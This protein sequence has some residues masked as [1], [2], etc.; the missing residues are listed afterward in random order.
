MAPP[1]RGP[2]RGRQNQGKQHPAANG[3]GMIMNPAK[4]ILMLYQALHHYTLT[5][6]ALANTSDSSTAMHSKKV[7]QLD[8]YFKTAQAN[9]NPEFVAK[10]KQINQNWRKQHLENHL[11]HF[12]KMKNQN[13]QKIKDLKLPKS[14]LLG[15]LGTAKKWAKDNFKR[16]F[17]EA[18]FSEISKI[19][20]DSAMEQAPTVPNTHR[21]PQN[22][23]AP[24]T[25]PVPV[26]RRSAGPRPKSL[27]PSTAAKTPS[28]NTHRGGDPTPGPSN[29]ESES[30]A[31]PPNFAP[32]IDP[33]IAK[34]TPNTRRSKRTEMSPDLSPAEGQAE[35]QKPKSK[36][37][38]ETTH[39][40]GNNAE[41]IL[42]NRFS[43]L[44]FCQN[45]E[46]EAPPTTSSGAT[47]ISHKT[48]GKRQLSP[49]T[50]TP[51]HTP[52]R[53][54][55]D[56]GASPSLRSPP[57]NT[58]VTPSGN[59]TP[60]PTPRTTPSRADFDYSRPDHSIHFET[61][62][63]VK[64]FDSLRKQD[65]G[66]SIKKKWSIPK[67]KKSTVIIGD[68]NLA[69][70]ENLDRDDVEILSYPEMH[71]G[72]M[73]LILEEREQRVNQHISSPRAATDLGINP[74]HVVIVPSVHNKSYSAKSLA[75]NIQNVCTLL[76]KNFPG[77]KQIYF[78]HTEMKSG[79]FSASEESAIKS[80][81]QKMTDLSNNRENIS[82][83][84]QINADDFEVDPSQPLHWTPRCAEK[85]VKNIFENLN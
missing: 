34:E 59:K 3:T 69:R 74:S 72:R 51:D 55:E 4:V 24:P 77:A 21:G 60:P 85:I 11:E 83:I 6:D 2:H 37:P 25:R 19:V 26:P 62:P 78:A 33:A 32:V 35:K 71:L 68:E 15:Y 58:S 48:P 43:P 12:G 10:S 65:K 47:N 31:P 52:K 38:T 17:S 53:V 16:K 28:N 50:P 9:R 1:H 75:T 49:G 70:I 44:S 66:Q 54:H 7:R 42:Q 57:L 30:A 5:A 18:R 39:R 73:K 81:N 14:E 29:A 22:N 79:I 13:S 56:S 36:T 23:T 41:L 64:T 63:R 76:T 61:S 20:L 46:V 80:M 27:F 45:D 40:G 82:V 67:L 8:S 84:P